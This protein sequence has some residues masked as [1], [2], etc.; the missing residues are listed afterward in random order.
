MAFESLITETFDEL[1]LL[2]KGRRV[3]WIF[4]KVG[5]IIDLMGQAQ[6]V[7][8]TW[9]Q[10]RREL[11]VRWCALH[12]CVRSCVEK[13]IAKLLRECMDGDDFFEAYENG[14]EVLAINIHGNTEEGEELLDS[15]QFAATPELP[16]MSTREL[17][18]RFGNGHKITTRDAFFYSKPFP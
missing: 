18:A 3:G 7:N 4:Y 10:R 6:C 8:R 16:V 14:G 11:Q 9:V 1:C 15:P 17:K 13:I 12:S 2:K 5:Q